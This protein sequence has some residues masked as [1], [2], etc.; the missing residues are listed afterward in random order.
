MTYGVSINKTI[1]QKDLC[2]ANLQ[3]ENVIVRWRR[4]LYSS[5]ND[6][7]LLQTLLLHFCACCLLFAKFENRSLPSHI[8]HLHELEW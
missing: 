1:H 2:F 7:A 8:K 3:L 5:I 6:V 4:R